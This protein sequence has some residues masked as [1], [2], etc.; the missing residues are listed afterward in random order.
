MLTNYDELTCH[1]CVET[2]DS[3]ATSDRA[4][5][6]KLWCNLHDSSGKIVL[7]TGLGVYPNRNVI[8]GYVCRSATSIR[9]S[10]HIQVA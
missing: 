6:E 9:L 8:D 10:S 1:Q 4:W 5:T 3:V 7:A 2:F